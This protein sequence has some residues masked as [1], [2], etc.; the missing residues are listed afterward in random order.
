[1]RGKA[2]N[3]DSLPTQLVP[4]V[5]RTQT[6]VSCSKE[7]EVHCVSVYRNVVF[8]LIIDDA[9][10]PAFVPSTL[11][12][13]VDRTIPPDWIFNLINDLGVDFVA[14]PTFIANDLTS[15]CSMADLETESV[16][17]LLTRVGLVNRL[18]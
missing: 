18:A 14:G 13:I 16:T 17:N 9:N 11:F 6:R 5:S 8:V 15:Y 2:I 10:N 12:D 7:Y 1:M 4:F 3:W